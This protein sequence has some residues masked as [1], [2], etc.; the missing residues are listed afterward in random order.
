MLILKQEDLL[1]VEVHAVPVMSQSRHLSFPVLQKR[2]SPEGHEYAEEHSTRVVEQIP[3]LWHRK[4]NSWA[5]RLM[6]RAGS[7]LKL[8][9]FVTLAMVQM[10][11]MF[12]ALHVLQSG[13]IR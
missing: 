13:H 4:Y 2:Y 11:D 5:F 8:W 1:L 3:Q 7:C 6:K 10:S 12:Q 9:M